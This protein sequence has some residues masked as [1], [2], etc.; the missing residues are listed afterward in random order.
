[1]S[2]NLELQKTETQALA[3]PI[4]FDREQ[5]ELL[6]TTICK[7]A[8][9]N[10]LKLF[11]EVCKAKNLDPFSKQIYAI[12]R[13]DP[14]AGR[15]V[16]TFQV[17]ID[18]FRAKA[19]ATGL[20]EGQLPP[21]WCGP[22]GIWRDVWLS[23]GPPAACRVAVL[24]KGF[25]EPMY[26]TALYSEYVQ[27]KKDGTP[28]SMWRKMPA[29][30]LSKV[31]EALAFRKAFPEQLGGLYSEEEMQQ[32]DNPDRDS[33]GT[34]RVPP[35]MRPTAKQQEQAQPRPTPP[36]PAQTVQ[37]PVQQPTQPAGDVDPDVQAMFARMTSKA[38]MLTVFDE[39][40]KSCVLVL[41][42]EA[43]EKSYYQVLSHYGVQH[44]NEFRST[45]PAKECAAY[46]FTRLKEV[47]AERAAEAQ[48]QPEAAAP[49]GPEVPEDWDVLTK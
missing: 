34:G 24:R 26:A 13:W 11:L 17:G 20:Y 23:P 29:G 48:P 35:E 15:E 18:G 7:G 21:Q 2:A 6:K 10:E 27:T 38:A 49:E 1:M 19:D 37:Q 25:R 39:L 42:P 30:Q 5:V 12:K 31:C 8:T 47:Q 16:M 14:D 9:D 33:A 44:A 32:A 36:P 40:K 46:L 28:N 3:K 22:D 4:S 41:G 45:K 43:G